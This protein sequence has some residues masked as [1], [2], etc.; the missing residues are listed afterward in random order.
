MKA[1]DTNIL[2]RFFI[3]DPDDSQAA[4]QRPLASAAL[5]GRAFV[6]VTVLLE[7]EWVMRGFYEM[8]RQDIARVLRALLGIEHVSV[9]DRGGV[10]KALDAFDAGLDLADALHV[11]R[12]G[13]AAE[14]TTFDRR[15]AKRA[16]RLLLIPPVELLQAP[17]PARRRTR[18]TAREGVPA[19]RRAKDTGSSEAEP[20]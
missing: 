5:S 6:S 16:A 11:C 15:L 8:P 1:L 18:K 4:K 2:A 13:H 20:R 12:S 14:F 19:R 17:A 10:L 3:D 9:E 7:F